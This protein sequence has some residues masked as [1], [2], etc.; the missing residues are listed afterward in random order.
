[1]VYREAVQGY[2]YNY[3]IFGHW[4]LRAVYQSCITVLTALLIYRDEW[5]TSGGFNLG[6]VPMSLVAYSGA[7]LIQ[8]ATM[9]LESSSFTFINHF[10]KHPQIP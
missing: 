4:T 3:A 8:T 1:M 10:G 2:A 5:F 7:I 9:F 6:V